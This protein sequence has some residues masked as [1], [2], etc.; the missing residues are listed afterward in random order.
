MRRGS[1]TER[2]YRMA[3]YCSSFTVGSMSMITGIPTKSVHQAVTRLDERGLIDLIGYET[4]RRTNKA[5]QVWARYSSRG[6]Y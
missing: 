4:D 6:R 3:G 5:V 1:Q 2:I